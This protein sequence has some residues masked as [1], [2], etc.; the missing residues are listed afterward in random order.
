MSKP[1]RFS[2]LSPARQALVRLCQTMNFGSIRKLEIRDGQPVF[3]PPPLVLVDVKL[4][5]GDPPRP[6]TDLTDF[7]LTQEVVRLLERLDDRA[8]TAIEVLEVRAGIPRWL[9][10]R[11]SAPPT[12]VVGDSVGGAA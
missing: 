1:L 5:G 6:E 3:D 2:D 7:E 11:A 4:D 8:K 10:F 9:V 12:L